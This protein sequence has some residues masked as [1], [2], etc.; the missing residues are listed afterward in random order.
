[1]NA[2]KG[3][4]YL[5]QKSNLFM[6]QLTRD[7]HDIPKPRE[8]MSSFHKEKTF[9]VESPENI[10]KVTHQQ[11]PVRRLDEFVINERKEM[12]QNSA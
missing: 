9:V 12:I 10:Y 2:V 8:K 11:D 7:Y 1:M 4:A 6:I 5:P 3:K